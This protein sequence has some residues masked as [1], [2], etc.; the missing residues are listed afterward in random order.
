MAEL[1]AVQRDV[2]DDPLAALAALIAGP[3]QAELDGQLRTALPRDVELRGITLT[4]GL[5][6]VDVS[7]PLGALS[8]DALVTAI[9][10]L[11]VTA[12]ELPAVT[13]VRIVIDGEAQ[14]W[15]VAGGRLSATDLT[16]FD[17]IELVASA[18]PDFPGVPSG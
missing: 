14:Q 6:V 9:A 7:R 13:S 18:Q 15:P 4:R 16:R 11:V 10:Q 8:G 1:V 3:T 17:Y 2:D 5:L 12:D